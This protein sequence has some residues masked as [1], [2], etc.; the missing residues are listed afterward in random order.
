[1]RECQTD[2]NGSTNMLMVVFLCIVNCVVHF[3]SIGSYFLADDF[4]YIG[5]VYNAFHGHPNLLL[6]NFYSNSIQAAGTQFYRPLLTLSL[7]LDYFLWKNNALGYHLS[8]LFYQICSTI[9]LYFLIQRLVITF[10]NGQSKALAAITATLFAVYPLHPE[11][12]SWVTCRVDAIATT[13]YLAAFLLFLKYEQDRPKSHAPIAVLPMG[14]SLLCY[15][16]SLLSKEIAVTL[17]AALWLWLVIFGKNEKTIW[18]NI[19]YAGK[20]TLPYWLVLCG[21]LVIRTA[22]LGTLF[23]GYSGSLALLDLSIFKRFFLEQNL[24]K[25]ILPFNDDLFPPRDL[26]RQ[27][28]KII[29][30]IATG[31]FLLRLIARRSY[32]IPGKFIIYSFLWFFITLAPEY[33]VFSL[34][35]NLQG[36]RFLYLA[37]VP[38]CLIL[39]LVLVPLVKTNGTHSSL[40]ERNAGNTQQ[41]IFII[42]LKWVSYGSC[43]AILLAFTFI[44]YINNLPWRRAGDELRELQKALLTKQTLIGPNKKLI[45]VNMPHHYRGA[46]MLYNGTTLNSLCSPALCDD[47]VT[48]RIITFEHPLFGDP[49]LLNFTR[50]QRFLDSRDKYVIVAWQRKL[51]SNNDKKH[52]GY[53]DD[54]LNEGLGKSDYCGV[55][56]EIDFNEIKASSPSFT[57]SMP[58]TLVNNMDASIILDRSKITCINPDKF[59]SIQLPVVNIQPAKVGL[60]ELTA[61]AVEDNK[62]IAEKTGWLQIQWS[63]SNHDAISKG[64]SLSQPLIMDGK[65]HKYLF[66]LS[67]HK[68]WI[69]CNGINELKIT[70][71]PAKYKLKLS[72]A[73]FLNTASMIPRLDLHCKLTCFEDD[74]GV[75]HLTH[76]QVFWLQYDAS[77]IKGAQAVVYQISRSNFWFEHEDQTFNSDHF[78]SNAIVRKQL[79]NLQGEFMISGSELGE[80]YFEVHLGAV[81][82]DGHIL[83]LTSYP[84]CGQVGV[85]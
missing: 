63:S 59:E 22:A 75:Y 51:S 48:H 84:V 37:S 56:R 18:Q 19:L 24:V 85:P 72:Q 83:G 33:S 17:P 62:S 5:Y 80:D 3:P 70:A 41:Q 71:M 81:D 78:S 15:S 54:L 2:R 25:I 20:R 47:D 66:N 69:L 73:R 36:S 53:L 32:L 45:L 65:V 29:Y 43:L 30:A 68:S 13:F 50:L 10:G 12:I 9:L 6:A 27:A 11:V 58:P 57:H 74:S 61:A 82:K 46:H 40:A 23:G 35:A 28:L 44:A 49:D 16:C 38:L 26:F 67:E 14:L 76:R 4:V 42:I 55:L 52:P 1:M 79:P 60:L 39:S 64:G 21:Y 7:A 34:N 8:N 31:A 77:Q